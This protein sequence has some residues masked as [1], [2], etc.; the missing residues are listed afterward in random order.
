VEVELTQLPVIRF[1]GNYT[2]LNAEVGAAPE[3]A[4]FSESEA[5]VVFA[6]PICNPASLTRHQENFVAVNAMQYQFG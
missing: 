5:A 1:T 3:R 6:K 2:L 4:R